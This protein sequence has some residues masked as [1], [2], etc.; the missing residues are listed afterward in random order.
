MIQRTRCGLFTIAHTKPRNFPIRSSA[1]ISM[2]KLLLSLTLIAS[3]TYCRSAHAEQLAPP[4]PTYDAVTVKV[5]NSLARNTSTNMDDTTFRAENVTLKHLLVNAYGIR[6]G[7]MFDLPGWAA[8]VR[9]DIYAKVSDPDLKTLHSLSKEQ[10]QAMITAMLVDRFHLKVHTESKT[11]PVYELV[12]A[13]D[14]PKLTASAVP[15]P[16]A[17]NPDPFGKMDVHNTDISATGV[18]LSQLAGN[19][20]FPLDRTVIDKTGLTGRYDFRLR[21]T[22]DT[23]AADSAV[24]DAP[25]NLFMAIQEQLGLKLQP[26]KGPVETLVI[27]H[28]EQPSEN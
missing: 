6:E 21:W 5:N 28:V 17:A 15:P 8:S 27:D 16:D 20:S 13:K 1:G 4:Q 2:S 3:L 14:G 24:A 25:P 19:L 12:V 7:L 23:V 10:R 9:F 26:A 18:T 11:L 22:A